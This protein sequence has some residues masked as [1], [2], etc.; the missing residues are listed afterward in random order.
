MPYNPNIHHRRSIRLQGY[1]Y[2]SAGM[3]FITICVQGMECFFGEIANGEMILNDA[4]KMVN[5]WWKKIPEKFSDIELDVYQIMPNHFHAIVINVG[6]HPRVRPDSDDD[7]APNSDAENGQ[8]HGS[9]PTDNANENIL[10]E[11]VGSPLYE[12]VQWFK[13]MSTNEYIRGV[14]TL[15]WERFNGK[16]WQRNYYEHI[17]RDGKSYQT[18]SNYIVNNPANWIDDK[19][20]M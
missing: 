14:K 3:Y 19:F 13:T 6:V 18:I 2:S 17:I 4:G 11:H 1:D 7:H 5:K 15:G 20:H 8:T 10:G 16:L 12:I 9:A